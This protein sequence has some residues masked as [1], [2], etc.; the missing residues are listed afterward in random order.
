MRKCCADMPLLLHCFARGYPHNSRG[1]GRALKYSP[2]RGVLH[3]IGG[4][5]EAL[6]RGIRCNR[7]KRRYKALQVLGI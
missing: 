1:E 6:Y 4:I 7:A 3:S 2:L 5:Y